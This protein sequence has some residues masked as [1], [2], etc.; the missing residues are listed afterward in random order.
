MEPTFVV[1][2]ILPG[3]VGRPPFSQATEHLVERRQLLPGGQKI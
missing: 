2:S 3:S 1:G